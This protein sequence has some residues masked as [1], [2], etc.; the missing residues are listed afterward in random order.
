MSTPFRAAI[1]GVLAALVASLPAGLA[2][3][4]PRAIPL[5]QR[6]A[7]ERAVQDGVRIV[8]QLTLLLYFFRTS[9]YGVTPR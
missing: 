4:P 2:A 7:A 9:A 8:A 1:P 6:I 3:E 5:E